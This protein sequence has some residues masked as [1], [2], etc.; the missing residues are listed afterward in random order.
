MLG[1]ILIAILG[2]AYLTLAA[3]A[4]AD[5][6]SFLIAA[7]EAGY[8]KDDADLLR[9]GYLVCAASQSNSDD[10]IARGIAAA[11]RLAGQ[12]TDPVREQQFIDIAQTHLCGKP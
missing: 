1:F 7:R 8:T 10:L 6:G 2:G 3:D 9:D 11:Q 4:R 5:S 12:Q